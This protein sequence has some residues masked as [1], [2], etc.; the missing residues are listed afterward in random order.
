M[1]N[2]LKL[3]RSGSAPVCCICRNSVRIILEHALQALNQGNA[4]IIWRNFKSEQVLAAQNLMTLQ[5]V[6][7]LWH[8]MLATSDHYQTEKDNTLKL[9]GKIAYMLCSYG[10]LPSRI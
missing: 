1:K 7:T 8:E 2:V 6:E 4:M 5:Q 3:I 10:V 9:T